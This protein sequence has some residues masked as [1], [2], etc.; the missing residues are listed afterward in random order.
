MNAKSLFTPLNIIVFTACLS[1]GVA[2][3]AA[4]PTPTPEVAA[5]VAGPSQFESVAFTDSAEA[6]MLRR[7]YSILASGDHDY[8][9]HRV[10]A[11]HHI[12]RAASLLG[13]TLRGDDR[14]RQPQPLSDDKLR[15]AQGL[16][17]NVLGAAEV[18][19]QKKITK[20]IS[21]AIS[22][23]NEALTVR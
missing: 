15:E 9:G 2:V 8:N 21:D 6:G 4:V 11:M 17:Q 19:S 18:K 22:E 14:D 5:S 12:E 20:Q 23:I 1:G 13:F 3:R 7:A 16:L 10:K